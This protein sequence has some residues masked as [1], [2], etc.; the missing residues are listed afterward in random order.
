ME[1]EFYSIPLRSAPFHYI[2]LHSAPS[3]TI[4]PKIVLVCNTTVDLSDKVE[5]DNKLIDDFSS[6]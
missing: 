2:P 5:G 6:S 1:Y 3:H 4:N